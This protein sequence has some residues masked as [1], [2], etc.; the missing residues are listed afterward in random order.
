MLM[1]AGLKTQWSPCAERT[2]EPWKYHAGFF[3]DQLHDVLCLLPEWLWPDKRR[4]RG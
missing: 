4:K 3:V 1:L 2:R